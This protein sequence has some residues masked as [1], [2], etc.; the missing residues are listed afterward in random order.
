MEN[1]QS[2]VEPLLDDDIDSYTLIPPRMVTEDDNLRTLHI[3][4]GTPLVEWAG[5]HVVTHIWE[6]GNSRL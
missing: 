2:N 3:I 6:R 1:E 4:D 5:Q